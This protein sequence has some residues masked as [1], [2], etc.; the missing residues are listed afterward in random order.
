MALNSS[1][2][3]RLAVPKSPGPGFLE[4]PASTAA[5]GLVESHLL[6]QPKWRE[7]TQGVSRESVVHRCAE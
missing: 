6:S 3:L 7:A 5:G 4:P 2:F 1:A